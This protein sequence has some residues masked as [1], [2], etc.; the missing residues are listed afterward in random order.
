MKRSKDH[1]RFVMRFDGIDA[2]INLATAHPE[3][4]SVEMGSN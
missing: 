3:F 1:V 2:D 4:F